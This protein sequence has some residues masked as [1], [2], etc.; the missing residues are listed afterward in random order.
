MLRQIQ[1]ESSG[2]ERAIQQVIDVNTG[3]NEAAGL[4]QV[5]P[6]TFAAYRDPT[7]PN[8]RTDPFANMVA[9]LNYV[10]ARYGDPN[11]VWEQGHGYDEGELARGRGVMLKNVIPPERVSPPASLSCSSGSSTSWSGS[12][13]ATYRPRKPTR[14]HRTLPH[15]RGRHGRKVYEPGIAGANAW[16]ADQDFGTQA[17]NW[18]ADAAKEIVGQFTDPFGLSSLSD[19]AIDDLR[20]AAEALEAT[21]RQQQGAQVTVN[22]NGA[23]NPNAV[24]AAVVD[25]IEERM[26]P[27]TTRYRNGG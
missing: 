22:V 2:N 26:S 3:G 25:Q 4:L 6:G 12:P 27:V 23:G 1:S 24:R 15:H 10:R 19:R 17:K 5:T 8:D 14:T 13:T 11:T 16:A 7:L 9:A 21:Q 20:T 18:G